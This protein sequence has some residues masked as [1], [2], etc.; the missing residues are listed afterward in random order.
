[1]LLYNPGYITGTIAFS[2]TFGTNFLTDMRPS[3]DIEFNFTIS[4]NFRACF[5]SAD[6]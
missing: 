2:C 5:K 6:P 4:F 1:M 3:P